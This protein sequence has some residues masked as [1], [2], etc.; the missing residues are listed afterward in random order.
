M[1]MRR[2]QLLVFAVVLLGVRASVVAQELRQER[3]FAMVPVSPDAAV[4]DRKIVEIETRPSNFGAVLREWPLSVAPPEY[5]Q[6]L[7]VVGAGRY[8]VWVSG[9]VVARPYTLR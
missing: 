3:L 5:D 4:T 8:V 7:H 2:V 6:A 1:S 9:V